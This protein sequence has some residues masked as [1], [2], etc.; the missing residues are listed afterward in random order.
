MKK[1]VKKI[2][3]SIGLV[4]LLTTAC[5]RVPKQ[6]EEE[7]KTS[8]ATEE[9]INST[10]QY[11]LNDEP[12]E[13]KHEVIKQEPIDVDVL[14]VGDIL[15]H[16]DVYRSGVEKDGTLNYDHFFQNIQEDLAEAELAIVN[17]E[18]ILG[19]KELGI[20]SYPC[21]NSPQEIGD[22]EVKAG[23]DVILHAT[24]HTLDKGLEGVER[25]IAFWKKYPQIKAIGINETEEDL[26]KIPL[27][28]YNDFK[29]AILNYTYGTNGIPLPKSKPYIV[30][31]L[32]KERV[33]KDILKA[34]EIADMVIVC[35]H[36]GTEY[37]Y[38]PDALQD[39]YVELFSSLDVDV[40]IGTHPHVLEPVELI[41]N[42]NGHNMLVYYSLGN[43]VS[44][45]NKQP[46]MVGG[47]AKVTLEKDPNTNESYIKNYELDPVVMQIG[48]GTV[49]KLEDYNDELGSTNRVKISMSYINDLC[50]DILGEEYSQDT[51]SLKKSLR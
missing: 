29:I 26:D 22:A 3:I 7:S 37:Q 10:S 4:S 38:V 30:N 6:V 11:K 5:V 44:G 8:S 23:F 25:T 40:V 19:G 14:M 9:I 50:S 31:L 28:E 16:T 1:K 35:P 41:T 47:L 13:E 34:K 15:V 46:R 39:E 49:Y 51:Y 33:T 12:Q 24:N 32:D 18:T 17:Q 43:F 20:S 21:F 27:Y 45:Q 42:D 2:L 48:K 36:W